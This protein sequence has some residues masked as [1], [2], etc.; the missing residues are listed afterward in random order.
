M[1]TFV[2]SY[3]NAD[4]TRANRDYQERRGNKGSVAKELRGL[5]KD[6]PNRFK[7][8]SANLNYS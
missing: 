1:A 8:K 4:V 6:D 2:A 7:T 5:G 3:L